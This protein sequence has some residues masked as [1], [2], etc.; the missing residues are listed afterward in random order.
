MSQAL[1]TKS[2]IIAAARTLFVQ[3]GF[4]GTSMGSIA[5]LANVTHSLLFHHFKNKENLWI[6][7]KQAIACDD[8]QLSKVLPK[9]HLAFIDFLRELFSNS[10]A[11]Y[12]NHPEI[13]RIINWQRL[14]SEAHSKIGVTLS[15]E[16]QKWLDSFEYYQRQGAIKKEL[17]LEFVI[18]M[19]LSI[20]SSA[21]L[22]HYVF[23]DTP[24]SLASYTEFCCQ[25]FMQVLSQKF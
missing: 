8:N 1:S 6:E 25:A 12:R 10:L 11:F 18:T 2:K 5:K 16:M 7:M 21:A 23:I 19:F 20:T 17:N 15:L 13:I 4:S 14:E 3:H 22:D 24:E 9:T